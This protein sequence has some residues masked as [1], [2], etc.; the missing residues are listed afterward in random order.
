MYYGQGEAKALLARTVVQPACVSPCALCCTGVLTDQTGSG[1]LPA[2][3]G[4][5][6]SPTML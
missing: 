6:A 2:Y 4:F 3:D 1:F 5:R